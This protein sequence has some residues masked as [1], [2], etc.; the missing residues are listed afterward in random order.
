MFASEPNNARWI[1][2]IRSTDAANAVMLLEKLHSKLRRTAFAQGRSQGRDTFC[3]REGIADGDVAPVRA[4][5]LARGRDAVT[6]RERP[7]R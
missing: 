2:S 5:M 6:V 1:N 4:V 3:H 7:A